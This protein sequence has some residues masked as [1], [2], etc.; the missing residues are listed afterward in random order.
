MPESN[1]AAQTGTPDGAPLDLAI[2]ILNYNTC[3]LLRNCLHS[4]QAQPPG[5]RIGVCVVEVLCPAH[6]LGAG[7]RTRL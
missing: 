2:V 4:L 6:R 3:D 7:A 5:L 1:V